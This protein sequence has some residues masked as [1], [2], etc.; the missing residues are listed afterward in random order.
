MVKYTKLDREVVE[1]IWD[2]FVFKPAI[3]QLFLDYTAAEAKW[4]I[5]TGKFP[6]DTKVPDFNQVLYPDLLQKLN[7]NLVSIETGNK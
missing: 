7:P 6:E 5:E 2:N 4:A 3:N 1:E